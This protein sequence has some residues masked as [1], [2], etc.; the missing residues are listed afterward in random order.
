MR[1]RF[2]RPIVAGLALAA[3]PSLALAQSAAAKRGHDVFLS[4]G[5]WECH[6]TVG[7]GGAGP[8]LVPNLHPLPVIETFVRQGTEGG[9]P[10]YT[11]KVLS[12][13]DL[14]AI[15]A[16]LKSLPPPPKPDLLKG[17]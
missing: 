2:V 11:V 14:A 17:K 7:Q 5:C 3:L 4:V 1:K 8:A 12:D 6:G 13:R 10:P 16:Y 15:Y 9:M